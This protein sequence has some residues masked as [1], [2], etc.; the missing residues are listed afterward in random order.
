MVVI[1]QYRKW[2]GREKVV[3]RDFRHSCYSQAGDDSMGF[4]KKGV[5][6]DS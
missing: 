6:E 3:V 1:P 5:D 2:T 4:Q